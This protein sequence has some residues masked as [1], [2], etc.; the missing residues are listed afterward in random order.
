MA[1]DDLSIV[2]G[3]SNGWLRLVSWNGEVSLWTPPKHN[4]VLPAG[5]VCSYM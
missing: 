1:A 5:Y 2:L 3:L 4:S